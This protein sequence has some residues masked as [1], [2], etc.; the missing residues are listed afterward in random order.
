MIGDAGFGA[1][2]VVDVLEG[3]GGEEEMEAML[4]ES[5][6]KRRERDGDCD[7]EESGLCHKE[8]ARAT[9]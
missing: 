3:G 9:L 7:E 8:Y 4:E 6:R 5:M 2:D 1:Q